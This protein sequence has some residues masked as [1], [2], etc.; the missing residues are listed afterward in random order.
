MSSPF[1]LAIVGSLSAITLLVMAR[2]VVDSSWGKTVMPT[3]PETIKLPAW[4][5]TAMKPVSIKHPEYDLKSQGNLY[6]FMTASN[7]EVTLE[8]FFYENPSGGMDQFFEIFSPDE[9][10]KSALPNMTIT[11]DINGFYGLYYTESHAKLSACI[12][13]RGNSTV[14]NEQFLANRRTFDLS[15]KR[16]LPVFFGLERLRDW[17]CLWVNFSVPREKSD[18]N[19]SSQILVGAWKYLNH[20]RSSYFPDFVDPSF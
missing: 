17:R 18:E 2:S 11:K 8:I 3:L 20:N 16:F 13:P 6:K 4:Q 7:A 5:Q 15:P 9:K 1:K 10:R 14:T 19:K 12:N